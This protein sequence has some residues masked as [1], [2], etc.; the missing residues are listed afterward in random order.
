LDSVH[1][2]YGASHILHGVSLEVAAG[3]AVSILGR[4]GAG[5][6]TTLLTAMGYLKPQSGQVCYE[7]R[8]ISGLSPYR[9]SRRGIGFVPQERGIFPSLTVVE[10]LTVAARR[11]VGGRWTLSE[12]Y[13]LFPR[14]SERSS[15]R[16]EQLSGGEQQLL[17]I[18]R[19]LML[20]PALL[21][22]DE[23]SEG[24]SPMMTEEIITLLIQLRQG[25]LT[26]LLVEQNV[27]AAMRVADRHYVLVKG[28]VR[29]TGTSDEIRTNGSLLN[30][31][32][33]V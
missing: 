21:I 18:A 7:G 20:N 15:N 1:A 23:P 31:H 8:D 17:A 30:A 10:N 26:I 4:N 32:L 29:Y 27:Q 12:I 14:L 24:L 22:L 25:G 6:T 2:C 5:K 33:S 16:G 11:G 28:E 3:E 9:V 13:R 19:G